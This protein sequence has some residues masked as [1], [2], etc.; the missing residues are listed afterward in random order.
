M[1]EKINKIFT[2]SIEI[3]QQSLINKFEIKKV[4]INKDYFDENYCTDFKENIKKS[5]LRTQIEQIENI[6]DPVL[7]W[8][9]FD[10]AKVSKE[11]IRDKF[12]EYKIKFRKDHDKYR[13]TSSLKKINNKTEN[14]LYVGKVE[15]NFLQRVI[16][17]LGYATSSQTAGMQLK[18]WYEIEKFGNLT[19]NYVTF[20]VDMK[21]LIAI[22]EKQLALELK[23]LIGKY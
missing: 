13:S 8:F 3:L 17:H 6:K 1:E 5:Y 19:L 7:Y 22:I 9:E 16:T 2:D 21:Y 15:K 10:E 4:C 11:V 20:K 23:P 12:I 14:I 18:H